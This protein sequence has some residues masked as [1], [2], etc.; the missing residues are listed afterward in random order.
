MDRSATNWGAVA[1]AGVLS[2]LAGGIVIDAYLYFVTVLPAGGSI[3]TLWQYV[4][5]ALFPVS[6]RGI[7]FSN[8]AYA[9]LGLAVHFAVSIAWAA[10]YAYL[11]QQRPFMNRRWFV[12]GVIYGFV[13]YL[14]MQIVLIASANFTW[15]T[16]L[17]AW[18]VPIVGHMVFFGLP[19]AF[20]SSRVLPRS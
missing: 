11:A 8:P 12:S 20:V 17:L 6:Q 15:P 5:S 4:A 19:V 2:G 13:V 1:R 3:V 7:A 18:L 9:V 14:F 16:S 10:G